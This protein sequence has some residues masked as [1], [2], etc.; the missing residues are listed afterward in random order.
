MKKLL[1]FTIFIFIVGHISSQRTGPVTVK[2]RFWRGTTY[3]QNYIE[4]SKNDIRLYL[5]EHPDLLDEYNRGLTNQVWGTIFGG[6][7][8]FL[9]GYPLGLSIRGDEADWKYAIYSGVSL[10]IGAI[11]YYKLGKRKIISA[12]NGYNTSLALNY[13]GK[14]NSKETVQFYIKPNGV[15]LRF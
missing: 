15:L 7:G 11:L 9:I 5:F 3:Y 4:L 1:V 6:L 8:G 2:E 10:S 14:Y 12:I 13:N